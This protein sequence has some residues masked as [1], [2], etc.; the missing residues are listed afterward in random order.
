MIEATTR[1]IVQRNPDVLSASVRSENGKVLVA[2][3]KPGALPRSAPIEA[4]VPIYQ[5][6]RKWGTVSVR[7]KPLSAYSNLPLVGNPSFRFIALC[8]LGLF[9]S[10]VLYLYLAF[11]R[12]RSRSGGIPERVRAT[13]DTLV[14]G[15]LLLDR[16]RRIAL[17]NESFA[18][19]VG[20]SASELEGRRAGELSWSDP[21]GRETKDYLPWASAI[22][23]GS[24]ELGSIVTLKD[25]VQWYSGPTVS[26]TRPRS[27]RITGRATGSSQPLM[28]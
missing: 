6:N 11:K 19:T 5:G 17:V 3:T 8:T 13:L 1:A 22:E 7:F 9:I 4:Q 21:E 2:A 14:E 16:D 25:R 26:P 15:V 27:W 18:R 24:P 20:K 23:R 10:D 28:T 12:E